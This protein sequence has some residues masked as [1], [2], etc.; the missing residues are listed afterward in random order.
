MEL[1][2]SEAMMRLEIKKTYLVVMK[3]LMYR[4]EQGDETAVTKYEEF[5]T[6]WKGVAFERILKNLYPKK[7][8]PVT[9]VQ[10]TL[11]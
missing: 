3:N 6:M 4:I 10:Q 11:L 1:D 2:I 8:D 9:L 5:E 7:N